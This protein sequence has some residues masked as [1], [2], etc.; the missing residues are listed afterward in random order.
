MKTVRI[1]TPLL[2]IALPLTLVTTF[3]LFFIFYI[4]PQFEQNT[5][6]S[7][8]SHSVMIARLVLMQV[9]ME[10]ISMEERTEAIIDYLRKMDETNITRLKLY[11]VDGTTI[12]STQPENIG[13]VSQSP[14]FEYIKTEKLPWSKLVRS[15]G[16]SQEDEKL[17]NHVVETYVPIFD[18]DAFTGAFE[19]YHNV[20]KGIQKHDALFRLSFIT[21]SI[22]S[23]VFLLIVTIIAQRVR[24]TEH[25]RENLVSELQ[26]SEERYRLIFENSGN[27][28][29]VMS[30][31]G[32][33]MSCDSEFSKLLGDPT[34]THNHL[35]WVELARDR[36]SI[37]DASAEPPPPM[38]LQLSTNDG[39]CM[40]GELR[41][42]K[43]VFQNEEALLV[44]IQNISERVKNEE[45]LR[46][47][48]QLFYELFKNMD[49]GV[50]IHKRNEEENSYTIVD[51][52][53]AAEGIINKERCDLIGKTVQE[54]F[55]QSDAIDLLSI[56]EKVSETGNSYR[57]KEAILY[58]DQNPKRWV[59][60]NVYRLPNGKIVNIIEDLTEQKQT[61]D[62]FTE[63][64]KTTAGC[65]GQELFDLVTHNVYKWFDAVLCLIGELNVDKEIRTL[66]MIMNGEQVH[67]FTYSV[68][69]TPCETAMNDGYCIYAK[70][71]IEHF[72]EDQD[73]EH[74]Q[75]EGYAGIPLLDQQGE[76]IG[77]LNIVTQKEL[78]LPPH[79][80]QIFAILSARVALEIERN[81]TQFKLRTQQEAAVRSDR[82]R[83]LGEMAGGMAHEFNQPLSGIRGFAEN[84]LISKQRNWVLTDDEILDKLQ[85]IINLT[86]RM[87][88]LILHVR[89]F[90]HGA[91]S[92]EIVSVNLK[93]VLDSALLLSRSQ[94]VSHG[95]DITCGYK[96]G[97]S[98]SVEANP[99]VLEEVLLS[100]IYNSRDA[101]GSAAELPK[102]NI[103]ITIEKGDEFVLLTISDTGPGIAKSILDKV[104][105]PFFTSKGPGKGPGLGLSIAKK[106]I[107][108]FGG[109]ISIKSQEGC[110]TTVSIN[111][112][113]TTNL[114][115]RT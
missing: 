114:T 1:S 43:I 19:I 17:A 97:E 5:I 38:R 46:K 73:L 41:A 3:F 16:R 68:K 14:A 53:S 62:F 28:L 11:A 71:V 92:T 30:A 106:M 15:G 113:L 115:E 112:C 89:E 27:A 36:F 6:E 25:D 74:I 83:S 34:A 52:N 29:A 49:N 90:A 95:I 55:S 60:L 48:E 42:Q 70:N 40:T 7:A 103:R 12:Y 91:E 8:Q 66:S 86:E 96:E 51:L 39:G 22:L 64:V 21:M 98:I 63:I 107:E 50:V 99:F 111:L 108:S 81:Q 77:V 88:E 69:G 32:E 61:D 102:K 20:N 104:F 76:A 37:V 26:A 10:G 82:L 84:M 57:S 79:A 67:D 100:L 44:S 109:N 80:E 18:N 101:I 9:S 65:G 56:L 105:D 59:K 33:I 93:T 72:P 75:A 85:K 35:T 58:A 31:K 23:V 13:Q 54:V 2:L 45:L 4:R 87:A 24:R 94:L 78:K 110:G 47:N